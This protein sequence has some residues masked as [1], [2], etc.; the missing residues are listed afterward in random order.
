MLNT[1]V[2]FM[3]FRRPETTRKV[4][5]QIAAARPQRLFI[6]A[7]GPRS[8]QEAERCQAARAVVERIDWPC[9][10]HRNYADENMGLRKR[11]PSGLDWVFSHVERAIILEDDCLPHPT[12][13]R[14]CEELLEYYA[15]DTRVVHITGTNFGFQRTSSNASD[16]YYFTRY[17]HVWGWAT[18]K[19]AWA[20]YDADMEAWHIPEKR[21]Q[22]L[23]RFPWWMRSYWNNVY[24]AVDRRQIDTWAYQW[25]LT[26]LLHD[27]LTA[28]PF[29]NLVSHIGVG[30]G[31]VH[32]AKTSTDDGVSFRALEP[33]QFPLKHPEV[34]LDR[35][36]QAYM[37]RRTWLNASQSLPMRVYR[38]TSRL[39]GRLQKRGE[40]V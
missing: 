21:R 3:I 14:F 8:A 27:G 38:K 31:A 18:W 13:F 4:F 5:E 29:E 9:E 16:S 37:N 36:G 40:R 1:P 2:A 20:Q 22:I 32:Y 11:I 35:A 30:E 28:T 7:D 39:I 23:S 34:K 17:T 26:C 10:V 33:V 19:R 24:E 12:F 25:L 15:D 6:V